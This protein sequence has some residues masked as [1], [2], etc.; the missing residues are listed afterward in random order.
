MLEGALE[1][2][3]LQFLAPYVD[4]ISRDKLHLGAFS[5]SLELKDL[6]VKPEALALL[7][8]EGF[9]VGHGGIRLISLSIPWSKLYSGKVKVAIDS[10]HIKVEALSEGSRSNAEL[11][12]EL[13]EAKQKAIDV[14]VSQLRDIM[15][16][17]E[18]AASA[19]EGAKKRGMAVRLVRKIVNNITINLTDVSFSF[20]N[21]NRGLACGLDFPKLAVL[22]TDE[23]FCERSNSQQET[24]V[25]EDDGGQQSLY[26][27]MH[28][29]GLSVKM[30]PAGSSDMAKS[31][32]ILSPISASL[33]LAHVPR[34]QRLRIKL[35][36]ARAEKLAEISLLRS[37]V[38]HVRRV[39]AE[40]A[41]DAQRIHNLAVPHE[42]ER[43]IYED[44]TASRAEYARLYERGLMNEWKLA[45]A[46]EGPL[47]P[48]ELERRQ[49]LEDAFSVRLIARERWK[50]RCKLEAVHSEVARRQEQAERA[51]LQAEKAKGGFFG[52][53]RNWRSGDAAK[54]KEEEAVTEQNWI[55][56]EEREQLMADIG[57]ESKVEKVDL[58]QQFS[59][60]FSLGKVSL[61]FLDDRQSF[62]VREYRLLQLALEAAEW[63]VDVKMATDHRGQDSAEWRTAICLGSLHAMH[64]NQDL[65]K[66][67][68]LKHGAGGDASGAAAELTLES[69]LG[70]AENLLLVSF[71]FLPVEIHLLPGVV[72]SL[73]DFTRAP[74][75]APIVT[76]SAID[77][78]S[79]VEDYVE[80]SKQLMEAHGER[81][82]EVAQEAYA[83]LPDKVSLDITIASPIVHVP[84]AG[85][86]TSIFS[87]GQLRISTPEPCEYKSIDLAIELNHT[88]MRAVSVHREWYDMIQPVPIAVLI[89]SRTSEDQN[90]VTVEVKVT[91]AALNLTPQAVRILLA[92]PQA[93]ASV[94]QATDAAAS[95]EQTPAAKSISGMLVAEELQMGKTDSAGWQEKKG[96][97]KEIVQK[98][99]GSDGDDLL[100]A[101]ARKVEEV[102]AK[103]FRL[104]LTLFF[105]ALELTM[106]DSISP[107]MRTRV[108]FLQPGVILYFQKDP[109]H[110]T[111][112]I[113]KAA[114]AVNV[115]N[116][117]HGAWEP[118]A[119]RF[120]LGVELSREGGK[121]KVSV[122]GHEP[123]LLDFTPTAV[124]KT[125]STVPLFLEALGGAGQLQPAKSSSGEGAKYRIVN[126]SG[127]P[128]QVSFHSR[129][130]SGLKTLVTPTGSKWES[131]D[132]WVLPNFATSITVSIPS[133]R[134][135]EPL[136]LERT[137]AVSIPGCGLVAEV[138]ASSP[139]HRLVLLSTP[140]RVHN[141]SDLTLLVR[142]HNEVDMEKALELEH[143]EA[144]TC[145]AEL[146]GHQR[147]GRNVR[148]QF[149]D[150]VPSK[151]EAGLLLKPNCLAAVPAMAL[152]RASQAS[153]GSSH[154]WMSVRPVALPVDCCIPIEVGAE[155]EPVSVFCRGRG[156]ST[157]SSGALAVDDTMGIHLACE[158]NTFLHVLPFPVEVTTVTIQPPL[159]LMN[160]MPIMELSLRYKRSSNDIRWDSAQ[161]VRVPA[162]T[163]LNIYNFPGARRDGV[164][165]Q[166]RLNNDVAWSPG[167]AFGKEEFK[168]EVDSAKSW[169][170]KTTERGAPASV[171]VEPLN[172][173]EMRIACPNWFVERS[174]LS[175]LMVDLRHK[176][177]LLPSGNGI[178]LLPDNCHEESCQLAISSREKM[179]SCSFRMPPN[180]SV[181]PW[182]AA[183]RCFVFNVQA[184]D[185]APEDI[186]GARCQVL[187]LRPRL[188]LTNT[189]TQPLELNVTHNNARLRLGAG[190]SVD[191]H[192]HVE[193]GEEDAP[194]CNLTFR[195]GDHWQWSS[196]VICGDAQAGSNPYALRA[197]AGGAGGV[198]VWSVEIA[199]VRGALAVSFTKGSDYVAINRSKRTDLGICIR[200]DDGDSGLPYTPLPRGEEVPYGWL[201]PLKSKTRAVEVMVG[202]VVFRVDDV[203][204][205]VHQVIRRYDLEIKVTLMGTKTLLSVDD[206]KPSEGGEKA[207]GAASKS[208]GKAG[209]GPELSVE[210][211]LSRLGISIIEEVPVARELLYLNLDLIRLELQ[212]E[213]S[214]TQLK[215]AI[216]EAQIDCQLPGRVDSN[217]T[218]RRR[219]ESLGLL[220]SE[221]SAVLLANCAEGDRAFLTLIARHCA[222][223]SR[224]IVVP[225]IDIAF[226]ALDVTIDDKWLGPVLHWIALATAVQGGTGGAVSFEEL[227]RHAGKH[228]NVDYS[229]PPLPS[230]VQMDH[231]HIAPVLMTM[232]CAFKLKTVQFLPQYVR[233]ALRVLS[234][235]GKFTLDG[236]VFRLEDR[237]VPPHRGSLPDFLRGLVSEYT[238]N[239]LGNAGAMLGKSSV[240]NLPRVPLKLGMTS[241]SYMSDSVGLA[242]GEAASLLQQLTFDEEYVARQ[243]KLRREKKIGGLHD[244]VVEAGKSLTQG[245]EGL[246]DVFT[247]PV[248]GAQ[249]GGVGGFF[250][251][252]G[253]GVVGT[254]VKP[255]SGV[256]RAAS[257]LGSG[258]AASVG[259]DS[260]SQKRRRMRPRWR[261]PRL[262][263]S[264]VGIVRPWD[265]LHAELLRL[266]G[267]RALLG[268]EEVLPLTGEGDPNGSIVMLL[269]P[270]E[271]VLAQVQGSQSS[272]ASGSG[273]NRQ[274][275][276]RGSNNSA[277]SSSSAALDD[278]M[279][280]LHAFEE[281][282]GKLVSQTMKPINTVVYG[283]QDIENKLSGASR[284]SAKGLATAAMDQEALI[285]KC[286]AYRGR[287]KFRELKT[288]D[289]RDNAILLEGH[290]GQVK[291]LK[292]SVQLSPDAFA[293]LAEGFRSA[294]NHRDGIA[295]WG[296][297][298]VALRGESVRWRQEGNN[299]PSQ[300]SRVSN[301]SNNNAASSGAGQ[302]TVEVWEVERRSMTTGEWRAPF[303]PTDIEMSWRWMDSSGYHHPN[304]LPHLTRE[305]CAASATPPI[306]LD[307]N[308]FKPVS[309]WRIERG[310]N[311]D[312]NGWQYGMAWN[313]ST[314]DAKPSLFNGMR[315][316]RWTRTYA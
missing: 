188:V 166:A 113:D 234:L 229:P 145:D 240:L 230:V 274:R 169:Q 198:E 276:Q 124:V 262:L 303:L 173:L 144:N 84:V 183:D 257:D 122:L 104:N 245:V 87:L 185:V 148:S 179:Q 175:P 54:D 44:V 265:E 217:T 50:V 313:S 280:F 32:C 86:G 189:S 136:A 194:S 224:D 9:R 59:F 13:Q 177:L 43:S 36:V 263:F 129:H 2:L 51:R 74:E 223:S 291:T 19:G 242:F 215:M 71:S 4:G 94:L 20:V 141:N 168:K 67:K 201:K 191:H 298:Q 98:V 62:S 214:G 121:T 91:E 16:N 267:E 153:I 160:A 264:Q 170:L 40:L 290:D 311:T 78:S 120:H 30:A 210:L 232:W 300:G 221:T 213:G 38:K 97:A 17:Q 151:H 246:L 225:L 190:C 207:Q 256:G 131:L 255:I 99:L 65:L 47:T 134:A 184:D 95:V 208:G 45:T 58:P 182:K 5:G 196:H 114:L 283:V 75:A 181:F 138:L 147:H 79:R 24:Q 294:I 70:A 161:E 174:G 89:Q 180:F 165:L 11:L 140:V 304:L 226:D 8:L 310:N 295:S 92:T 279:D 111:L 227:Q 237:T 115:L 277:S 7:G 282:A 269:F 116:P 10:I 278:K 176:G 200:A 133:G 154:T 156:P 73:L 77:E 250:T 100:Q 251:G 312:K 231:L 26:K 199:P 35:E 15:E 247:K 49:L 271:L 68:Q 272:N 146:L 222:T 309:E 93:M 64:A 186:F 48:Q 284:A 192:W 137:G 308:L 41:Q 31:A 105:D 252:L 219:D 158:S 39:Q 117:R 162:L 315:R 314:W 125:L 66:L 102:S 268:I 1:Q 167:L 108:E 83:R 150:T 204:L 123:L 307:R 61:C 52:R 163:K 261:Q 139:S 178:T 109:E 6:T 212:K 22:S 281:S 76:L 56:A 135:S 33:Q 23:S 241:I 293:A 143:A 34:E 254:F 228:I 3:L 297:L 172:F 209:A 21:K 275:L 292:L 53:L 253:K 270:R 287:Y 164:A 28:L 193:H 259:P 107:V 29:Q 306:E 216:S 55:T 112:N 238:S 80:A 72:E 90:S 205:S 132:E 206:C 18:Q 239:L 220:Q 25:A 197:V 27:L 88:E 305:K 57:D 244:G 149:E 302:R 288:V 46:T 63:K 152:V 243:R 130:T 233:T 258:L 171:V 110:L 248:E 235:S 299:R 155:V 203:R 106:A 42:K 128:L 119:E 101:A 202:G 289:T 211:K 157:R 85:L 69:K 127:T 316:R 118:V 37:Q 195:I 266:F 12:K 103:Q 296:A 249:K 301:S 142:F 96:R 236:A 81:A 159:S 14:R 60:E 260:A 273:G 187:T 285:D 126:I 286:P 218:D 82:K